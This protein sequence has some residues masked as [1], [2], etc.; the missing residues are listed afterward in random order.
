M[1]NRIRQAAIVAAVM[2]LLGAG[3]LF[4]Q[5]SAAIA[6]NGGPVLLGIGNG[7]TFPTLIWNTAGV[8]ACTYSGQV[9]LVACG[10]TGLLGRTDV[11]A[12]VEGQS[13][14]GEGVYGHNTGASGIGVHGKTNGSGS[15]VYGEATGPGAGVF[16]DAPNGTGVLAR[17][18][19][20][21]ALNVIGKAKFSRSGV[22]TFAAGTSS[23]T[24]TL[25][26]VTT[27]SMILATAQQNTTRLVKAA[28][29]GTGSFTIKLNGA[30]PTGG[31]KV[32]YF[33]LN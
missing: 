29:P 28:V 27:A 21:V 31:L 14:T 3:G 19:S 13:D 5:P 30:A 23:K 11:G 16:G 12:G 7:E 26:G 22:V 4:R 20:G 18:T 2:L 1:R 8:G 17:S 10:T 9:G 6:A 33:V 24:V 15:G 25:A 32:A